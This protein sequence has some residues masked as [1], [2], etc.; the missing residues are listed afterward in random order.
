LF[1]EKQLFSTWL[2]DAEFCH[3]LSDLLIRL[4]RHLDAVSLSLIALRALADM[5]TMR[6]HNNAYR[7]L[8]QDVNLKLIFHA[9]M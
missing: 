8:Q 3:N 1:A 7:Y 9:H 5:S 4:A 6:L 2:T